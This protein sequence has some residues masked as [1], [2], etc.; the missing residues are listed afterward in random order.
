MLTDAMTQE[1]LFDSGS[2]NHCLFG[3]RLKRIWKKIS[4]LPPESQW[5]GQDPPAD[6]A[7]SRRGWPPLHGLLETLQLH[8]CAERCALS[9][10]NQGSNKDASIGISLAVNSGFR[11]G[12]NLACSLRACDLWGSGAEGHSHINLLPNGVITTERNVPKHI[13]NCLVVLAWSHPISRI[14]LAARGES[15]GHL[16]TSFWL[17]GDVGIIWWRLFCPQRR[18]PI[19]ARNPLPLSHLGFEHR[20]PRDNVMQHWHNCH[21]RCSHR[22]RSSDRKGYQSQRANLGSVSLL[23][24]NCWRTAE[25]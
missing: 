13:Q 24:L 17:P 22:K 6:P 19:R 7:L 2:G 15:T 8:N 3:T 5:L 14:P 1:A 9:I 20:W 10:S 12:H 23:C 18:Q 25:N 21:H 11:A 16:R 4:G